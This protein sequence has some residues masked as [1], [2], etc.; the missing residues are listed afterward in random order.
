MGF[1]VRI[2]PGIRISASK[3]GLRAGIGP[4][5]ARVHV[6]S[7]RP[8]VSTGAGPFTYWHAVGHTQRGRPARAR[9]TPAQTARTAARSTP[10]QLQRAAQVN[11]LA[12]AEHDL[13]TAHLQPFAPIGPPQVPPYPPVNGDAVRAELEEARLTR[14]PVWHHRERSAARAA[15]RVEAEAVIARRNADLVARHTAAQAEADDAYG[16]L[17]ANDHGAVM[18]A[19]EAAFE[20]NAHPAVPIDCVDGKATVVI[21]FGPVS[22]M[23]DQVATL[24]P[25][26]RPTLRKRSA[27]D[28]NALYARAMASTV[29][30]TVREAYAVAPAL[31]DVRI[32][33]VRRDVDA[34]DP[35]GLLAAV[36]LGRFPATRVASMAW[37]RV[38][39][40]EQLLAAPDAQ[41]RRQGSAQQIVGLPPGATSGLADL[42]D[43]LRA[44]I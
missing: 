19:L 37:D 18:G 38:D 23:P 30:A 12:V 21:V 43:Q 17:L 40:L 6:G 16:A 2:A 36:Y 33:V 28:R 26:G 22:A 32:V 10:A 44:S 9:T 3:R 31:R 13:L 39:P 11:A 20:D 34:S 42:V 25:T 5:A 8:S 7:G 4:R 27:T 41:L 1:G 14:V 15:A 24:T 29:L 35:G